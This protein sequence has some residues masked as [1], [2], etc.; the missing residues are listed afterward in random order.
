[1]DYLVAFRK[2]N[3]PNAYVLSPRFQIFFDDRNLE[4]RVTTA[5]SSVICGSRLFDILYIVDNFP[6]CSYVKLCVVI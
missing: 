2:N 4:F 1:M 3:D 6:V 5:F